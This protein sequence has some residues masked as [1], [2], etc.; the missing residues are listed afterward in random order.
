MQFF[1]GEKWKPILK[2]K[3]HL[4]T[5]DADSSGS[6]SIF[7]FFAFCE[8]SIQKREVGL[9]WDSRGRGREDMLN[10][11]ETVSVRAETLIRIR[12]LWHSTAFPLASFFSEIGSKP[13]ITRK[14]TAPGRPR[15][16]RT[17]LKFGRQPALVALGLNRATRSTFWVSIVPSG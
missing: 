15:L 6:S 4:V 7:S 10:V 14:S 8:N 9:H 5:E 3:A 17:P 1:G 16:E 13:R 12:Q 2:V 11:L